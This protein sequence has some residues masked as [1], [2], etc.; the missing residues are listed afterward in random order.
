MGL[1]VPFP[2]RRTRTTLPSYRDAEISRH[3]ASL[4]R[5]TAL[6]YAVPIP[7]AVLC[8]RLGLAVYRARF[9]LADLAGFI[10]RRDGPYKIYVNDADPPA[11]QRFTVAHE[12]GHYALH[13]RPTPPDQIAGFQDG[14]AVMDAALRPDPSGHPVERQAHLFAAALLMPA[15]S[16][17]AAWHTWP[18]VAALARAFA[19]PLP[20]MTL[21][22][23]ALNLRPDDPPS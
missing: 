9:A 23:H 10:I 15:D 3:A 6:L 19:V 8:E 18:D 1:V 13:L 21:R 16:V 22:L 2:A 20:A 12:L 5:D 11:R 4:L 14:R 17:T 7:L